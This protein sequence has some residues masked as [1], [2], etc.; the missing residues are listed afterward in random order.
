[1]FF[2][3]LREGEAESDVWYYSTKLQ[4]QSL[5]ECLDGELYE[6]DLKLA[7]SEIK[8]EIEKQMTITEELTQEL[9][10]G[11]KSCL[12]SLNGELLFF[13]SY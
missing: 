9:R 4:L 7:L 13:F 1:M 6:K 5:M 12:D 11:K 2:Y 3:D 10:A 8:E